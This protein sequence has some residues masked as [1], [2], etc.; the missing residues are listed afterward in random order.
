MANRSAPVRRWR[1]PLRCR[2]AELAD[3]NIV[4]LIM[5]TK[6]AVVR[7]SQTKIDRARRILRT[8]TQRETVERAL[9][10]V[11]AEEAIVRP[12]RRV[13]AVGGFTDIFGVA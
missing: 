2:V 9:D 5:T 3:R 8:K 4:R 10:L 7:L 12:H 1:W 13:K 6:A 11:L